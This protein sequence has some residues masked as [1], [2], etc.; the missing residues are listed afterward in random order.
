MR[1]S[2]VFA[3]FAPLSLL[4]FLVVSSCATPVEVPVTHFVCAGTA[5]HP[6]KIIEYTA[7]EKA[8]AS[9][10]MET[11]L[12]ANPKAE[13]PIMMTDFAQTRAAIR[14]CQKEAAQ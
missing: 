12:R 6:V 9:S 1:P 11:L 3:I 4:A 2:S 10:E 5:K 13:V 14:A 8:Q 7:T